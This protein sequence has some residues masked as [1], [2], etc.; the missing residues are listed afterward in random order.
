MAS[1]RRGARAPG[2]ELTGPSPGWAGSAAFSPAKGLV[3]QSEQGGWGGQATAGGWARTWA[4][5]P[6]ESFAVHR[7]AGLPQ[8]CPVDSLGLGRIR[9]V[10][11]GTSHP[12]EGLECRG[13]HEGPP[14]CRLPWKPPEFPFS[15]KTV[16]LA[17]GSAPPTSEWLRVP[18]KALPAKCTNSHISAIVAALVPLSEASFPL[19]ILSDNLPTPSLDLQSPV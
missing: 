18:F 13:Q 1:R 6:L 3:T 12:W 15:N 16:P 17:H 8:K 10:Y 19:V 7:Q 2:L 11:K 9:E 5:A 14:G 4:R